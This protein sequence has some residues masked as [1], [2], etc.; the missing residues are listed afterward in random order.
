M[1]IEDFF[2][3]FLCSLLG[4]VALP[5]LFILFVFNLFLILIQRPHTLPWKEP[6]RAAYEMIVG[7]WR[8]NIDFYKRKKKKNLPEL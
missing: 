4:I 6:L 8:F 3:C 1:C 7:V 2:D 5:F